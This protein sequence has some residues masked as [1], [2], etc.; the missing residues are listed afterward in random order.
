ML[1]TTRSSNLIIATAAALGLLLGS[2]T[3]V[4]AEDERTTPPQVGERY[5]EAIDTAWD[6]AGTGEDP[7]MTCAKVKGLAVGTSDADAFQALIAC[8]VDIPARYFNTYLDAVASGDTTCQDLMREVLTK[9]SA[10]TMSADVVLEMAESL[11]QGDETGS[12]VADA[13]GGAAQGSMNEGGLKSPKRLVKERIA[14][15][16]NELCPDFA[17]IILD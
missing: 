4:F 1:V 16:T 9:L 6:Q 13:L 14:E 15:R 11:E 10:M 8:N 7:S 3:P 17:D 2:G 5:Q 12:A